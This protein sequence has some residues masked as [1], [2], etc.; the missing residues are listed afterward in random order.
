MRRKT[1]KT[2]ILESVDSIIKRMSSL[3]VDDTIHLLNRIKIQLHEASPFESEP[4]DCVIWVK[5]DK[6]V[7]ND[8]NP[9]KVAPPEMELLEISI[10]NDGYT[11]PIVTFPNEDNIEIID[12]FHRDRVGKESKIVSERIMGYLPIVSIRTE[13]QS[14]NDRIASTI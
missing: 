4:V 13:Q 9:N 11:Q 8:Y 2:D 6:V 1:I 7:A 3:D 12:G 14:K 5:N 10:I